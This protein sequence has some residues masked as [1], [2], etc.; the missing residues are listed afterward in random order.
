MDLWKNDNF[1]NDNIP[2]LFSKDIYEY[3][4]KDAGFSLTQEFKL[5]PQSKI[6]YLAKLKKD[7]RKVEMG[8]NYV[9]FYC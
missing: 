5:L 2:F 1:I 8:L 6:D 9:L 4:M 7:K 3:D